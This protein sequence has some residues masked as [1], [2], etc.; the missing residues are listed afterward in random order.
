MRRNTIFA[1]GKT[2]IAQF[3]QNCGNSGQARGLCALNAD[4]VKAAWLSVDFTATGNDASTTALG[5]FTGRNFPS[6]SV[7]IQPA[8]APR[9]VIEAILDPDQARTAKPTDVKYIYRVTAMGFGP[10]PE[11]QT[12]MQMLYRN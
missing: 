5:T 7:G 9:Y 6:G 1:L 8:Q 10:N 3:I 12:V 11:T 2:N 4:N